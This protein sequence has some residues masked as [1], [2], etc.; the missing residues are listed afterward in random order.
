[1]KWLIPVL[2]LCSCTS[3][4]LPAQIEVV[5]YAKT[6]NISTLSGTVV[7]T[8]GAAISDAQ[9]CSMSAGW[10]TELQCTTTDS[11][12]RWALPVRPKETLYFLRFVK[13]TFNQVWIKARVT[14]HNASPLTVEMPV[15]T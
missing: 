8:T 11:G 15:A 3:V 10:K 12:G 1:M 5:E 13:A 6:R 14:T 4:F 7:D 9:V 2:L